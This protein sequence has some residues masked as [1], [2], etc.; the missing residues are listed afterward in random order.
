VVKKNAFK[1]YYDNVRKNVMNSSK[2]KKNS[3]FVPVWNVCC[4]LLRQRALL[5]TSIGILMLR[6]C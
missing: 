5:R 4:T 1:S 3:C 6:A 2:V